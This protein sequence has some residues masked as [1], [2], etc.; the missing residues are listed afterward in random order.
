[1]SDQKE[2]EKQAKMAEIRAAAEAERLAREEVRKKSYSAREQAIEKDWKAKE[3]ERA[4][5][6]VKEDAEQL[7]RDQ[8]RKEA[9]LSREKSIADAE[10]IRK[11]KG[12]YK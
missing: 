12:K 9:L 1:M 2:Q 6:R 5:K 11:L 8:A 3:I 4:K 7:T 10:E